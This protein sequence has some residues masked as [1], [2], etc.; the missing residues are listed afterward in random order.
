MRPVHDLFHRA[1]GR[2]REQAGSVEVVHDTAAKRQR[3]AG[4]G[5]GSLLRYPWPAT[6]TGA[7]AGRR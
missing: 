2:T 7:A 3:E 6:Q 4:G 1:M 5:L